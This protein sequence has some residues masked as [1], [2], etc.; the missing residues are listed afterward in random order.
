MKQN[1]FYKCCFSVLCNLAI[2]VKQD[3]REVIKLCCKSFLFI[4][5]KSLIHKT[6][7]KLV[8]KENVSVVKIANTTALKISR[9]TTVK[10]G[11][12][13]SVQFNRGSRSVINSTLPV[14]PG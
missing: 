1:C 3:N 5:F 6:T 8:N 12:G 10:G 14:S 4:F 9:E 11:R 2:S 7:A 13:R